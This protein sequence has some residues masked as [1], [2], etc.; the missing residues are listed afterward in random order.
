MSL[1]FI[2]TNPPEDKK[3]KIKIIKKIRVQLHTTR[4][5]DGGDIG[6]PGS[7]HTSAAV[8]DTRSSGMEWIA[9][10]AVVVS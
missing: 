8:V 2:L 6:Q 1:S 5:L 7:V 4:S 10:A 3:N 9:V